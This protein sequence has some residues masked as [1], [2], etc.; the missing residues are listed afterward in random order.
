MRPSSVFCADCGIQNGVLR[1]AC[2]DGYSWFPPSCLDPQKCYLHTE[3]SLQSCDCHLNNLTQSV[4][5]CERTSKCVRIPR[6]ELGPLPPPHVTEREGPLGLC[7]SVSLCLPEK[8]QCLQGVGRAVMTY[9]AR[10][11][12]TQRELHKCRK[13]RNAS[14]CLGASSAWGY[15]QL[16]S[17]V[18]RFFWDLG[19][20]PE[21]PSRGT[22]WVNNVF[23]PTFFWLLWP[24]SISRK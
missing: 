22:A 5:F 8:S 16:T 6:G 1:C 3:G 10:L 14:W 12:W 9:P 4:H 21:I 13:F 15:I 7:P 11:G 24:T 2:D 19:R 20:F 18:L 23:L 17:T